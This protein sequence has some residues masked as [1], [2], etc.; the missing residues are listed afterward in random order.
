M[1]LVFRQKRN[2]AAAVALGVPACE[3][4]VAVAVAAAVVKS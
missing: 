1:V 4:A 2:G 3:T